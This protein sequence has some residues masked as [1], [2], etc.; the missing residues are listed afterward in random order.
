L[1]RFS[2]F[3]FLVLAVPLGIYWAGNGFG[4]SLGRLPA[5]LRALRGTPPPSETPAPVAPEEPPPPEAGPEEE[6]A[7][8]P[9]P[10]P[11]PAQEPPR[12]QGLRLFEEGRFAEAAEVLKGVDSRQRA[13]A[14]LGAAFVSAFPAH[15]PEAPYVVVQT[16]AGDAYEGF[17]E[18]REGRIRLTAPSGSTFGFPEAAIASRRTVPIADARERVAHDTVTE[19]LAAQT[20]GQRLFALMQGACTIGAPAAIAPL[21]ERCLQLDEKDPFFLSAVRN[22]APTPFQKD[23]YLAFATCQTPA[24]MGEET[25]VA[26]RAPARLGGNSSRGSGRLEAPKIAD[27]KARALVQEAAPFRKRGEEL[28]KKIVLEGIDRASAEEVSEAIAAFDKALALYEKAVMIEDSDVIYALSRSCSKLN[29]NLR[30]W[31]QQLE[32]R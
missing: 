26:V 32:G 29:F 11:P 12:R 1:G 22:R 9:T 27:E 23:L 17:L 7:P 19:G 30:F 6:P 21:L 31:K 3:V 8:A 5:E 13:L 16:V 25:V 2:L 20:T 10:E 4:S 24:V 15:V 14:M 28:Y 18:E